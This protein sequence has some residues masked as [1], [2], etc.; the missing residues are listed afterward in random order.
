MRMA[1][2]SR[3]VRRFNYPTHLMML[4]SQ[5]PLFYVHFTTVNRLHCKGTTFDVDLV[6][7]KILPFKLLDISIVLIFLA[8]FL[9]PTQ[10]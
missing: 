10:M 6:V 1:R 2:S 8:F 7:G 5:L 3:E 4:P 9:Y